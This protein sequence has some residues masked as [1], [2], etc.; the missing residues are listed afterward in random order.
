MHKQMKKQTILALGLLLSIPVIFRL[1]GW[2]FSRINPESAAGHPNYA[3]NY[4]WLSQLQ[5]LTFWT[6]LATVGVLWLLVCFLVIRSKQR[7]LS[8]LFLAA[9]GP[10]GFAVLA[11]LRDRAPAQT[12]WH[13]RFVRNLNAP[14]RVGYWACVVVIIWMLAERGMVFKRDLMI[15]RQAA[16]TGMSVAQI[17]DQ[18]NASS[19]MWAFAE[20]TEVM[21]G[22]VLLYLIWPGV[23][24]GVARV[25]AGKTPA[26]PSSKLARELA[27]GPRPYDTSTR[28]PE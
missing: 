24:N 2:L 1:G 22:V 19:G 13:E 16:A 28:P 9:F 11:M 3:H 26:G 14:L 23:F 7:S 15:Q 17:I 21:Y 4:Y 20:G 10:F 25:A 18:Q 6:M 12:D 5:H 8:W 27:P